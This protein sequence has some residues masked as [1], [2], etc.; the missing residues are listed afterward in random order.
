[1]LYGSLGPKKSQGID[2]GL[3]LELS[4]TDMSGSAPHGIDM[5]CRRDYGFVVIML[6]IDYLPSICDICV[7]EL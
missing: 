1:M 5:D 3:G 7:V 6:M 4:G 2:D